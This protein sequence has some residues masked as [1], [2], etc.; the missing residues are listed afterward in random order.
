MLVMALLSGSRCVLSWRDDTTD[1]VSDLK[2]TELL[3]RNRRLQDSW[4]LYAFSRIFSSMWVNLPS[5]ESWSRNITW[6][7]GYCSKRQKCVY[8]LRKLQDN[9]KGASCY[10]ISIVIQVE[11]KQHCKIELLC[12]KFS[13]KLNLF[14][15]WHL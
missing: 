6:F 4:S 9:Q 15:L 14:C 1:W 8:V 7:E 5:S 3:S 12:L 2:R 13:N 11:E 10:L